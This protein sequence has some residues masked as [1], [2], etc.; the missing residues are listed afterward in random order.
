MA[1]FNPSFRPG[2]QGNL[3][4]SLNQLGSNLMGLVRPFLQPTPYGTNPWASS[5]AQGGHVNVKSGG[6]RNYGANYKQSEQA[7]GAA[8]ERFRPGAGFPGQQGSS[9]LAAERAYQQEASR[10]AQL[11]AQDPELKR[12]ELA[13]QKAVAA[14]PGSAAE[15][16]AE[17]LGMQMW[18][19]ANPT[20][21]AN[22]KPGQAGYDAIQ[23]TLAGNAARAGQGFKMQEQLVPTPQG[24]PTNVPAMPQGSGYATGYNITQPLAQTPAISFGGQQ[25]APASTPATESIFGQPSVMDEKMFEQFLKQIK[26]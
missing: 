21:A 6:L 26:K 9:S 10:V 13:R 12:Y 23:G 19:K 4:T 11:T 16:S 8:A 15:Q 25:Q 3:G 2:S 24:F 20:L 17:D 22:V 14:G 18:A 5:G 1:G 7:A